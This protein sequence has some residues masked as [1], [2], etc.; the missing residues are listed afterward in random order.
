MKKLL[1]TAAILFGLQLGFSD[2]PKAAPDVTPG[3]NGDCLPS[4]TVVFC[5]QTCLVDGCTK[6]EQDQ[7]EKD[8][9]EICCGTAVNG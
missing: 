4:Y 9:K 2:A 7:C 3:G 8:W 5:S 6:Q 1:F